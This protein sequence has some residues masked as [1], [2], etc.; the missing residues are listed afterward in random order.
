MKIVSLNKRREYKRKREQGR[1]REVFLYNA[2]HVPDDIDGYAFI[3]WKHIENGNRVM[4]RTRYLCRYG[5]DVD[6]V[7]SMAGES[8]RAAANEKS[9]ATMEWDEPA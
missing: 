2:R 5:A 6:R 1:I 3:V 7:P 8:L 9:G 4:I